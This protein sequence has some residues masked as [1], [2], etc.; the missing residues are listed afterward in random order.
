MP[1]NFNLGEITV[2]QP[3]GQR[4]Q[5]EAPLGKSPQKIKKYYKLLMYLA[6]LK[7]ISSPWK[8]FHPLQ[9][10]VWLWTPNQTSNEVAKP[11][12][13][14]IEFLQLWCDKGNFHFIFKSILFLIT[15]CFYHGYEE[16]HDYNMI[17]FPSG[18]GRRLGKKESIPT[19]LVT[20]MK[21]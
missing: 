15:S 6:P 12:Y 5:G 18:W 3:L 10:L 4:E 8:I 1:Q 19:N 16:Y 14:I 17:H 9:Y 7:N 11:L 2:E 21:L 13:S 20:Y